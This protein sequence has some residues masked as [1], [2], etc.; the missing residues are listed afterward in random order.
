MNLNV[1][2]PASGYPQTDAQRRYLHVV[3]RER[4]WTRTQALGRATEL[5]SDV[6]EL[7]FDALDR[8]QM[9]DLLDAILNEPP[10]VD[11]RQQRLELD[12]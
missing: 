7:E 3:M 4:G 12:V 8:L 11:P 9:S 2:K 1:L 5:N 6:S 10:W